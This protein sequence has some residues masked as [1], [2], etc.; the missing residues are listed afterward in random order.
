MAGAQGSS[1]DRSQPSPLELMRNFYR[2]IFRVLVITTGSP[3]SS[4][5][6]FIELWRRQNCVDEFKF[7]IA[8]FSLAEAGHLIVDLIE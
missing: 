1:G 4:R 3:W 7:R 2:E 6:S 5:P 8:K